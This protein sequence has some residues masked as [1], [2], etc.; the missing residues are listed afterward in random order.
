VAIGTGLGAMCASGS[1]L[2]A[3]RPIKSITDG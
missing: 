3:R 1:L 2:I